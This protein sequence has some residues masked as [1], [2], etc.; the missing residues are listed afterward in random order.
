ML[1]LVYTTGECNLNCS[2]CGGSFNPNTVPWNVKYNLNDLKKTI[3]ADPEAVII[4][5]GGEP[6]L[7]AG[8]IEFVMDNIK[9][10]RFGVQTNGTKIELLPEEYWK[11][12]DVVLLSIDGRKQVTDMYRGKGT[13]DSVLKSFKKLDS[14]KVNKIIAR[15]TVTKHTDIYEDVMHLF[16]IGF[17]YVHWQLNA[18]WSKKWNIKSWAYSSYLPGIKRLGKIFLEEAS[19]GEV[20]GIVPFLGILSA[21]YFEGYNGPPCGAGYK[22]VSVSTDGRILACPI[23]VFEKWAVLG[24]VRTGFKL[25]DIEI[26]EKCKTC[27]YFRYCGGRCLYSLMEGKNLWGSF[28]EDLDE[29]TKKT[30]E[31]VISL[32]KYLDN[33]INNGIID[34]NQLKYDPTLDSTE[35]IP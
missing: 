13:Y 18:I 26:P 15:M 4:F 25:K 8:L 3:E 14:I 21:H 34:K 20:L 5:Y 19:K 12:M 31:E 7:N 29:I 11:K 17:K 23:A 27:E 30:I 28:Y 16:S 6:L 22:S 10:K 24:D 2:Y 9:A 32:T 33:Y 35:V 1:W